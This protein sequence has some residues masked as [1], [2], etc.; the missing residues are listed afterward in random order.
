MPILG[1]KSLEINITGRFKMAYL[2]VSVLCEICMLQY[3][4]KY[5]TTNLFQLNVMIK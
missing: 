2:F 3:T 5:L 1:N 4:T